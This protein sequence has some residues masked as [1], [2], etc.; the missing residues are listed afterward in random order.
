MKHHTLTLPALFAVASAA[1]AGTQAAYADNKRL[2]DSVVGNVFTVQH[3][4]GCTNDVKINPQLQLAAQQHAVDLLNNRTLNGD[5]GSDGSMPQDRANA[6]GYRGAVA[7]TV[8]TNPAVA[9]SGIELI[10]QWYYNPAYFAIM[11]NCA[12]SQIGVWSENTPDRTVVVAVY[13]QPSRPTPARPMGPES[14]LPSPVVLQENVPL[15]PSPDYDAS[16]EVEF[17]INWLPW[18]LRGVYPPPAMPPQ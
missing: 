10:N 18:I 12:N 9:I 17:G 5:I 3:Q 4:A 6:A 7:E 14:G 8:A 11:S 2:N 13:G 1:V 16:D 15:D